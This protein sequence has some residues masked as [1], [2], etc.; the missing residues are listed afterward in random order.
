VANLYSVQDQIQ[1]LIKNIYDFANLTMLETIH[2]EI[3][4]LPIEAQELLLDFVHILKKRYISLSHPSKTHRRQKG[5]AKG[6][7]IIHAEDDEHLKDF[8]EYMPK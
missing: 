1:T 2:Q 7:L 3:D 8:Q 4:N 6:K 5:S